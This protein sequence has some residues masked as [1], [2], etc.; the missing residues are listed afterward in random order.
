MS[1]FL[2]TDETF[3]TIASLV[4]PKEV[5]KTARILKMANFRSLEA[6]YGE[7]IP[8]D[9]TIKVAPGTIQAARVLSGPRIMGVAWDFCY[10]ACEYSHWE[11]S[12]ARKLAQGLFDA[13]KGE[14]FEKE[15][16]DIT[17]A[18]LTA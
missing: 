14:G 4:T 3:V 8:E 5:W 18:E 10:Q 7:E 17:A 15:G 16:G 13:I 12:Y 1:A 9:V 2:C 11:G 6:L